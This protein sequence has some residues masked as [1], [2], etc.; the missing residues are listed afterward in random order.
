[1]SC[2]TLV[3]Q[4]RRHNIDEILHDETRAEQ[5]RWGLYEP[6]HPALLDLYTAHNQKFCAWIVGS[7]SRPGK[8]VNT[9]YYFPFLDV[10][11][12]GTVIDP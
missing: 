2:F 7:F 3:D 1:M 4:P 9:Q 6:V 10:K 12:R 5:F 8:A 11:S